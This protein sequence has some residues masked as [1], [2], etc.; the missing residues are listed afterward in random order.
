MKRYISLLLMLT[1]VLGMNAQK[2]QTVVPIRSAGGHLDYVVD[3]RGNRV[4]DYSYCG[5]MASEALIP[6]V[7]VKA[8]VPVAKGDRTADIQAALDYVSSLEADADGFR[9][10]VLLE[11]GQYEISQTLWI[12]ASGVVLRGSGMMAGGTEILSTATD[13]IT[14][15]RFQGQDDRTY[16]Q[17]LNVADKVVPTGALTIQVPG[18]KF[19]AGD[20][21][22]LRQGMPA[23][24]PERQGSGRAMMGGSS[25]S[26]Q[27]GIRCPHHL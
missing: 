12:K 20:H 15:I 22:V 19:K 27:R 24:D 13:R 7:P 11:A 18:H 21:I 10:A 16:E 3:E 26:W 23:M 9:G 17:A 2:N 5:Y 8:V 6:T 14:M 25:A 1:L 4:P